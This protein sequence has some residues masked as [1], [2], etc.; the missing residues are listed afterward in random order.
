MP[1][2]RADSLMRA[3]MGRLDEGRRALIQQHNQRGNTRITMSR[4]VLDP[5]GDVR[6]ER[7]GTLH[8]EQHQVGFRHVMSGLT[9]GS[10]SGKCT[11]Q[12]DVGDELE[13]R[14]D[15]AG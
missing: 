7:G 9:L 11:K 6:R 1:Q 4:P 2:R 14:R 15:P 8:R 13:F 3:A 10:W 5:R 12:P